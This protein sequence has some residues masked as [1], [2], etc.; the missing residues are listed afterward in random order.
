[1]N[2]EALGLWALAFF[3]LGIHGVVAGFA[4]HAVTGT[5][6]AA[7]GRKSWLLFLAWVVPVFGA[8][9]VYRNLRYTGGSSA[10]SGGETVVVI[11]PSH[12][13]SGGDG[14]NGGGD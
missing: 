2:T 10:S 11:D 12:G 4:S 14:G 1:M 9:W 8:V 7:R 5:P 6:S 13:G 3:A